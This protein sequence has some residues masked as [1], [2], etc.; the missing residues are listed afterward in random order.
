MRARIPSPD[1]PPAPPS[2]AFFDSYERATQLLLVMCLAMAAA[3]GA[4]MLLFL[5]VLLI[6]AVAESMEPVA[7]SPMGSVRATLRVAFPALARRA[8]PQTP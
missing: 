6:S 7:P 3:A 5:V 2:E 8:L 1:A 4:V